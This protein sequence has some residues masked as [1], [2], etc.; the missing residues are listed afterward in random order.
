MKD[1]FSDEYLAELYRKDH[2][3]E[4]IDKAYDMGLSGDRQKQIAAL[5]ALEKLKPYDPDG[6]EKIIEEINKIMD[7]DLNI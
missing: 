4:L 3:I 7:D 6:C 2:Y 1:V 5:E